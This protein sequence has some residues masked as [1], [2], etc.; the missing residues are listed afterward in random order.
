MS[1][2]YDSLV[3][4]S[5]DLRSVHMTASPS[6][7]HL[8]GGMFQQVMVTDRKAALSVNVEH[9]PQLPSA[10]APFHVNHNHPLNASLPP[11]PTGENTP[12]SRP[13]SVDILSQSR[14]NISAGFRVG[15]DPTVIILKIR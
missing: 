15:S 3:Q 11:Q 2:L 10:T 12:V 13:N 5:S 1:K 14:N 4:S 8:G 6:P 9:Y 7:N